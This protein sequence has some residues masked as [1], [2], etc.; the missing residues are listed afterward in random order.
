[1]NHQLELIS[2]WTLTNK[3]RLN[4][5]KFSVMWFKVS[6]RH[7]S[8]DPPATLVEGVPLSVVS[9]QC[10]LG[11]IFDDQLK[12]SFHVGK[13][14]KSMSYYLYLINKHRHVIKADL[15]KTLIESLVLSHLL[16]S[17]PVWGPS[18]S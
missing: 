6:N 8:P 13:V 2:Q 1:M 11:L 18:L 4:H 12:W 5:S 7:W 16:Y 10:Y 15:L 9:K 17:V 14:C 3:M